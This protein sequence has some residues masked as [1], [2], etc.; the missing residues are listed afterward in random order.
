MSYFM[1]DI[2][3]SQHFRHVGIDTHAK[4]KQKRS[5]ILDSYILQPSMD[6]KKHRKR[7]NQH[8]KGAMLHKLA[9]RRKLDNQTFNEL[10]WI[11]ENGK[12]KPPNASKPTISKLQPKEN[13]VLD[14][15]TD[16]GANRIVTNNRQY[17]H[18]IQH[19]TPIS[20][21]GCHVQEGGIVCKEKGTMHLSSEEG[22]VIPVEA[23]F[24]ETVDGT[25]ISSTTIVRQHQDK[26]SGLV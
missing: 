2:P 10:G 19:I 6:T 16:S 22:D 8:S 7:N 18:N 25:V 3:T 4:V 17:L 23:Y 14:G 26:Y 20:M 13:L 5:K 1:N 12:W 21:S 9:L 24:S 11:H 15:Q